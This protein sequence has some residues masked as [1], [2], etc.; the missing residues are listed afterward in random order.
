MRA[1]LVRHGET[2]WNRE[3]RHQGRIDIPLSPEGEAQAEALGRRLEGLSLARAVASPLLRARGTAE[4]ALGEGR[5]AMLQLDPGLVEMDHGTWEGQL[6][7]DVDR[8][9]ADLRRAWR[10]RPHEVRLPGGETL[11]EVEARA[12][13]SLVRACEGLDGEGTLLLVTHDGVLRVLLARILG[14]PLARVWSFRLAATGVTLVEGDGP[15]RLQVVRLNDASHLH[16]LFGEPNH[17]RL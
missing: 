12:W 10:E 8:E 9:A 3:G 13:P 15:D 14:L 11:Q 1:L 4:R 2:L 6:S 17:R 16:P 5:A 7:R